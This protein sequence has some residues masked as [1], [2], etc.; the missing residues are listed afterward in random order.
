MSN[1][2][3][4]Q[5][6]KMTVEK[7]AHFYT[8]G[9]PGPHIEYLWIACHGYGQMASSM[10]RKFTEL[11]DGKTMIVAPDGLSRFYWPGLGGV[12]ATCWMTRADR[13]D[14]IADYTR[15][16]RRLYDQCLDQLPK[17]TKVILF[18]FSQGCA[19][20]IRW[21]M[22]EKPN[23][24]ALVL[25][26]G[27]LPDDLDYRPH[28]EYFAKRSFYWLYGDRDEFIIP[29]RINWQKQFAEKMQLNFETITFEGRHEVNR[30]VLKD[31]YE[32][33]KREGNEC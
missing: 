25:W 10:I 12:P 15:Y 1:P 32:Q 16:L 30:E 3:P 29:K 26:A 20:Q 27:L 13:L 14:E 33:I 17:H 18:G 21:M 11:D 7:T 22:R 9:Q 4:F 31:L 23:Y 19:T 2:D 24:H 5:S 8:I 6:H 28:H